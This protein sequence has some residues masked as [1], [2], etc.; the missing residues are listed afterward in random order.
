MGPRNAL[1]IMLLALL[2]IQSMGQASFHPLPE[3]NSYRRADFVYLDSLS[4]LAKTQYQQLTALPHTARYDTLRY[5]ALYYLGRLYKSWYGRRD[6]TLYFGQ[7]LVNQAKQ[8]KNLF[9]EINGKLTIAD[10][11][12]AGEL[13]PMMAL[14]LNLELLPLLPHADP[15][16]AVSR[17]R[18]HVNLSKLY[19]ISRAYDS[20]LHHLKQAQ[21][22]LSD[23]FAHVVPATTRSFR[24]EIKQSLGNVYDQMNNFADSE[25]QYLEAEALLKQTTLVANLGYIYD[26]LA[27]LYLKY[28]RFESALLYGSKAEAIW[29][30]VKPQHESKGWGTLACAY[31]ALGRDDAALD[32]AHCVLQLPKPPKFV[33]EQTYMALQQAY[34]HRGDWKNHAL[35]YKKYIEVRDLITAGQHRNEMATIQKQA[36]FDSIT[37]ANQQARQLQAQRLLTVQKQFTINQLLAKA[38]AEALTEQATISEQ[39]RRL[40]MAQAKALLSRQQVAQQSQQQDFEQQSLQQQNRTQQNL[41]FYITSVSLFIVGML[42]LL[43]YT[44]QLRKRQAE[45]DL[46]LA[47]ER[48][49]AN[50][51]IIQTQEAER[52]RIAADLHDELGGTLATLRRRLD[53]IRQRTIDKNVER[54][55]ADAETLIQKSS[56]DIRRI[57][58][59]LMPPEF[60]RIGLRH[61]LEQLI[62]SQPAHPTRFTF[63]VSGTE[64]KL[65][66]DTE[67]NTYRIVSELI[68]NIHKHAQAS[69]AALQLLYRDD[70]LTITIE[71][72]G[73][74][75]ALMTEPYKNGGIGLKTS[76]L[77]AEYIGATLWRDPSEAGTLVVLDIPF[78]TQRYAVRTTLSNSFN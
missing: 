63:V 7:E 48:R 24:I 29:D 41:L 69:R 46:R 32:Y 61:A 5:K 13:S 54:D 51:R 68:H 27:E 23:G 28:N 3:L 19:T 78:T 70:R 60:A 76:S 35:Y 67:L 11:Y 30:R 6:S 55:F 58:H 39:K 25:K 45:A 75:S 72:D 77:R 73:L 57:S 56:D 2:A 66:I 31:A 65:P 26:D 49:D 4:G 8:G 14:R 43:L 50:T 22:L 33:L 44:S 1:F 15:Y 37:Q 36:E 64:H 16:Y 34:E 17:Y 20:A 71:D 53:D 47:S 62:L 18:I 21:T 59:N 38:E 9:Y 10:Y 52:Q 40:E 74:G 42:T 12:L